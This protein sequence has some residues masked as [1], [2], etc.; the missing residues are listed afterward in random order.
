MADQTDGPQ[1]WTAVLG[2]EFAELAT[3]LGNG[4]GTPPDPDRVVRFV[5][6]AV[7]DSEACSVT[8]LRPGRRPTT[9]AASSELPTEVDRIQYGTGEGPCLDAATGDAA[10]LV[11]DLGTDERWPAFAA[12]CVADTGVRS[13]LALR[14]PIGGDDEA[15]LNLYS[16]RAGAFAAADLATASVFAPFAAL[17]VQSAVHQQDVSNLEAALTSSRQ[18]GTAIGIL[19]ARDLVS[20]DEAFERLRR[21]S[22]DLN[23]KL[24]DIAADVALTGDLPGRGEQDGSVQ[25]ARD[26]APGP[27]GA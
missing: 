14:L 15:A 10:T 22:Q 25:D 23:R 16:R 2:E 17:A 3:A 12:R 9:V 13:I 26:V 27:P 24:R 20:S 19:M 8:F 5:A 7:P 11:Q 1:G 18:V 4:T 21:A 6:K